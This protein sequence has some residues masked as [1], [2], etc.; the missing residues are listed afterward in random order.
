MAYFSNLQKK[1]ILKED[2]KPNPET[3]LKDSCGLGPN[4][5][6]FLNSGT[7]IWIE[8]AVKNT[9]IQFPI[10]PRYGRRG[11]HRSPGSLGFLE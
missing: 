8:A 1:T 10:L 3:Y 5:L 9:R 4:L 2:R 7:K 11:Q 6:Y